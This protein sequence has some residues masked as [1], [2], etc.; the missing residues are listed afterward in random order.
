LFLSIITVSLSPAFF[1]LRASAEGTIG[2]V[3]DGHPRRYPANGEAQ[4][5][6]DLSQLDDQMGEGWSLECVT[7]I[8]DME[9]ISEPGFQTFDDAYA[10][11]DVSSL[12]VFYCVG[13]HEAE[14]GNSYDM[15]ALRGKFS[16][17][18]DW[19]LQTGPVNCEGT[20]YSFDVGDIHVA[21]LNQYFDGW[22]SDTGTDGNIVDALFQW[23]KDDLRNSTRP[24][25]IVVGHEPAYPIGRHVGDSLDK[26]PVNRDRFW[27]LLQTERVIANLHGHTHIYKFKEYEGVYEVSNGCCGGHAGQPGYDSFATLLYAHHNEDGFEI[28]AV[29][30]GGT[31]WGG[32]PVVTTK[33][34][35]DLQYQI[36]VNTAHGAGTESY[37]FMDHTLADQNPNP[38]WSGNNGSRWWEAAFNHESA[39][40]FNGE[41][42][43]GY[44]TGGAWPWINVAVDEKAGL[45]GIFQII[46]FAVEQR[47]LYRT[48]ILGVDYDDALRV[49]LNGVE[50]FASGNAPSVGTNDIWD[51]TASSLHNAEGDGSY[52]PSFSLMNISDHLDDLNEGDNLLAIGNWNRGTGSSDL[53][54][55]VK[56]YLV[57]GISFQDGL[58]PDTDYNG[59]RDATIKENQPDTN[60]NTQTTI[61]IDGDDPGGTGLD[62]WGIIRW[63]LSKIPAG[64]IVTGAEI[65]LYI[66]DLGESY[67]MFHMK[68]DWSETGAAWNIYTAG[69]SWQTAGAQGE[70]DRGWTVL[71]CTPSLATGWQTIEM[72]T[73]GIALVQSWIEDPGNNCGILIGNSA[74]TNGLDFSSREVAEAAYRPRLTVCYQ[75]T[76]P[77]TPS[78]TPTLSPSSTPTVTPTPS[79]SPSPSSTP[80]PS[81]APTTSPSVTPRLTVTPTPSASVTPPPSATPTCGPTVAPWK[82]ALDSGDYDGDGTG[83]IA[84]FRFHTGFWALRGLSRFYFGSSADIPVP[85]D[86][87]GDG[88]ADP[89][90]YRES[91]GLWVIRNLTRIYFGSSDDIPAPVDY[92]GDGSSDI[93]IFRES[94]GLWAVKNL[95]RTYFGSEGDWPVP[96]DY[97]A[98]RGRQI[99]IFRPATGLWALRGMSRF[100][101]GGVT[102]W[103]RA[104]DYDG[105]G[106]W[107]TGVFRPATGL[108]AVRGLS[109]IYFGCCTD[110]PLIMESGGDGCDDIVIFRPASGLWAVRGISRVYYG[111]SGDIPVG[112]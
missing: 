6:V 44:D 35:A 30:E 79:P 7:T 86:F 93:A 108:W 62:K 18:P 67:D 2:F 20:T 110:W 43:V 101:F 31:D 4:L 111:I 14:S 50:I 68:R 60:F 41:L 72:N 28:R 52:N 3:S 83:D 13:N 103:P 78:I 38:D 85:G 61:G 15:P 95:T 9:Y 109:R 8:G 107:E 32:T 27:N 65:G 82:P 80:T 73:D 74:R 24:H 34:S 88:C 100:Y 97:H 12:P 10:V 54:A 91:S 63:D 69:T 26:Y 25:K 70:D 1:A 23:L 17:Y 102:D 77:P 22:T 89:G 96:G 5:A 53:A 55:A 19:N 87:D 46:P 11:S 49:W 105:D 76:P 36:L 21:V 94:T 33:T 40:F 59:T 48:L 92:N 57:R 98:S 64:K 71:G 66:V 37:Y 16:G 42:G 58:H 45:Y 29:N 47:E 106:V 56:L 81:P 84:I 90:I 112:H 39:G 75:D 104:G 51:K 99:A